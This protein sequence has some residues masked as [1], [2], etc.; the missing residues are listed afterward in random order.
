MKKD[1]LTVF[2]IIF[3]V[4]VGI[5]I[6]RQNARVP[7][8]PIQTGNAAEKGTVLCEE[9]QATNREIEIA[10]DSLLMFLSADSLEHR[11]VAG[12][13]LEIKRA[14]KIIAENK[15]LAQNFSSQTMSRKDALKFV[16]KFKKVNF[17]HRNALAALESIGN[18][19][20]GDKLIIFT[21]PNEIT[22]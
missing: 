12:I 4:V 18:A 10:C 15:S 20:S 22:I 11:K 1:T 2:G 9:F 7:S 14:E 6:Y 5:M 21:F 17:I 19:M 16:T 8:V 3:C 13:R